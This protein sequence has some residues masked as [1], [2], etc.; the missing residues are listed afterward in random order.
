MAISVANGKEDLTDELRAA[1]VA[2]PDYVVAFIDGVKWKRF[3]SQYGVEK[4]PA[5]LLMDYEKKLYYD[6]AT[7]DGRKPKDMADLIGTYERGEMTA[8]KTQG[9]GG[10]KPF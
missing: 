8:K 4:A 5:L 9:G 6:D 1:A 10:G 3:L 7:E 2:H